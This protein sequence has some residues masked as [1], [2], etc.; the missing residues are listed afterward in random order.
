MANINWT[1]DSLEELLEKSIG[2]IREM[3]AHE[4]ADIDFKTF[5]VEN[6]WIESEDYEDDDYD[7][8]DD[9]EEDDDYDDDSW[10]DD[11]E[12]E[13][14][15]DDEDDR[16]EKIPSKLSQEEKD[17]ARSIASD[18]SNNLYSLDT[19]VN[20]GLYRGEIIEEVLD[21]LD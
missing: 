8:D 1:E 12:D 17:I 4:D 14:D 13:E 7:G 5:L 9:Y 18:I 21:L 6:G 2:D 20:T 19:V 15:W 11:E 10:D 3:L 16:E